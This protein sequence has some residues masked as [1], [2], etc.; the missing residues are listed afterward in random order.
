MSNI[1]LFYASSETLAVVKACLLLNA[2]DAPFEMHE[3]ECGKPR[4]IYGET[5]KVY[6]G[7]L[8][9][10]VLADDIMY[11]CKCLKRLDCD[12]LTFR[13]GAQLTPLDRVFK[14]VDGQEVHLTQKEVEL[15]VYLSDQQDDVTREILLKAIW[16]YADGLETHTL[17][18]HIYRLRQKIEVDP[19]N[20]QILMT[21]DRGYSVTR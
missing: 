13:S 15:L 1:V 17:E 4:L 11:A 10:G 20:P 5:V 12:L 9:I 6:S 18:T 19:A 2:Y 3:D 7:L 8:R 21:Q 16:G 14:R